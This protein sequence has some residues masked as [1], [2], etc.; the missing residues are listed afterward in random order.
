MEALSG[1]AW[2]R[3]AACA[4]L[5]G[6]IFSAQAA[7]VPPQGSMPQGASASEGVWMGG[8]ID[9]GFLG[10]KVEDLDSTFELASNQEETSRFYIRGRENLD[11]QGNY[12]RFLLQSAFRADTG[13]FEASGRMFGQSMVVL[14]GRWGEFA[15]GRIG[16]LKSPNG[17]YSQFYE[18]G[19][20]SP[21]HTNFPYE[22][23]GYTFLTDGYLNNALV[24]QT[25]EIGP[26]RFTAQYSNGTMEETGE[27]G[28]DNHLLT[29]ALR[30]K[31]GNWRG[32][33]MLTWQTHGQQ[34]GNQGTKINDTYDLFTA[35]NYRFPDFS[36]KFAYQY[37]YDSFGPGPFLNWSHFGLKPENGRGFDVHS[38]MVGVELYPTGIDTIGIA[39]NNNYTSYKGEGSDAVGGNLGGW[40]IN[41]AF[42]WRH[43]LSKRLTLYGAASYSKGFGVY[44]RIDNRRAN[45]TK[46]DRVNVTTWGGGLTYFF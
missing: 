42:I 33:T 7:I 19:G 17:D 4:T 20:I 46:L 27:Y 38:F 21:V 9:M 22:G 8:C 44:D 40:R 6:A 10:Q 25:S 30:Y 36:L 26:F 39:L 41:P 1:K 35:I 34:E 16:A 14:G 23:V 15:V 37:A 3:R 13:A 18:F 12:V 24:F 31:F 11:D 45:S 5:L 28:D 29:L 2:R 32:G 43:K